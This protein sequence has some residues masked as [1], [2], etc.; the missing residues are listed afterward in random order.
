MV[1]AF[2]CQR[3]KKDFLDWLKQAPCQDCGRGY[4]VEC[5]DFDRRPRT[6]KSTALS[7][8]VN[9]ECRKIVAE[10]AKCDLV[11]ANCHRIRTTKR[12]RRSR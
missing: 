9:Y 4:P 12:M 5:M 2:R 6:R 10:V 7:Y 1:V 8:G 3:K 11:C